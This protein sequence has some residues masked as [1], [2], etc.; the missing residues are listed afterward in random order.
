MWPKSNFIRLDFLEDFVGCQFFKVKVHI[1]QERHD[2][3][4]TQNNKYLCVCQR[5]SLHLRF[6]VSDWAHLSVFHRELIC[7][8]I[9]LF[10]DIS[11]VKSL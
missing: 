4:T 6:C 7:P 10:M 5:Y 8:S 1:M 3:D 9:S 11:C 2:L